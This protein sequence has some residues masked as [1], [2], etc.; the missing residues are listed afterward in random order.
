M[1]VKTLAVQ[2]LVLFPLLK[3]LQHLDMQSVN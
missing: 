3:L 1:F 2:F